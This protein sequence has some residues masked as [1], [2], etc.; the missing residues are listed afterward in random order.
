MR[1]VLKCEER[2]EGGACWR[3]RW[4]KVGIYC[5]LLSYFKYCA[6]RSLESGLG[7][8]DMRPVKAYSSLL[9]WPFSVTGEKQSK[10]SLSIQ[11]LWDFM[12]NS[13]T[14]PTCHGSRS[15]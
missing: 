14:F 13:A 1:G 2:R 8:V 7:P 5:Y 9:S 11:K 6:L 12:L 10:I 15:R 3:S 4:N